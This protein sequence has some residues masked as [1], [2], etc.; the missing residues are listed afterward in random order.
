MGCA[1]MPRDVWFSRVRGANQRAC[2]LQPYGTHAR[3]APSRIVPAVRCFWHGVSFEGQ[4]SADSMQACF[5]K[6]KVAPEA[7][8]IYNLQSF[9]D[10]NREKQK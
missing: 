9:L 1:Q 6:K 2:A 4:K 7:G 8:I 3:N 5:L 10:T